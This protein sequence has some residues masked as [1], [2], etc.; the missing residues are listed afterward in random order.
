MGTDKSQ[1]FPGAISSPKSLELGG[2]R[3]EEAEIEVIVDRQ[4]SLG[5]HGEFRVATSRSRVRGRV[6]VFLSV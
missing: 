5:G 6:L 2:F 3:K 4:V 1:H